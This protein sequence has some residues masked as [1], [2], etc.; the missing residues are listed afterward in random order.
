MAVKKF[1]CGQS[2]GKTS[3]DNIPN[4]IGYYLSGFADGE[5]SFNVSI[6][7]RKKD[8]R[9]GWKVT[10]S[11]NISQKDNSVP[12]YVTLPSS[13]FDWK[14]RDGIN[15]IPIEKR[16]DEDTKFVSG[17]VDGEIK[18]ILLTPKDSPAATDVFD[19]TPPKLVSGLI[20]ERGI[21]N[22][23][24]EGILGMFPEKKNN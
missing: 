11:F 3:V 24:E 5:G 22:S 16:D 12:F 9:H 23:N 7:N 1:N 18:E 10:L 8:Y 17:L 21:C 6:I 4:N 19:V 13:T 14:I 2:A 20:T 15:E